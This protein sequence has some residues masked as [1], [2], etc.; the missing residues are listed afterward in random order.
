MAL[1]SWLA[2]GRPDKRLSTR[3]QDMIYSIVWLRY[4]EVRAMA[5]QTSKE[6]TVEA[7]LHQLERRAA[8]GKNP[9]MQVFLKE[10]IPARS[11][12]STYEQIVNSA[13]PGKGPEV[14]KLRSLARSF[15]VKGRIDELK[16]IAHHPDVSAILPSE[17][18]DIFPKPMGRKRA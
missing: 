7:V 13:P 12:Q 10:S 3:C 6:W 16:R 14:G 1:V 2:T 11:L 18:A 8:A 9:A 15:V 4:D 17:I 5:D